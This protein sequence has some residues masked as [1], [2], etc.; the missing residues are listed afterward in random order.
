MVNTLIITTLSTFLSY[1]KLV[2]GLHETD[3]GNY[4]APPPPPP[5]AKKININNLKV[6]H[7]LMLC[8][9][10]I[11]N[12]LHTHPFCNLDQYRTKTLLSQSHT[13]CQF[14]HDYI[15]CNN[16]PLFGLSKQQQ[17]CDSSKL[18]KFG[19]SVWFYCLKACGQQFSK[20]RDATTETYNK[21]M[22]MCY[23]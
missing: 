13:T 15:Y 4:R 19:Y 1:W 21:F 22:K 18:N 2:G 9:Y 23:M 10:A 12:N 8:T 5:F 16:W 20:Q 7:L 6:E 14:I 17:S 11:I 3:W